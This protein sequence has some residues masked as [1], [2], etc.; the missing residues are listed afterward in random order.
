MYSQGSI[1]LHVKGQQGSPEPV[2]TELFRL[3][4]RQGAVASFWP[5]PASAESG[6]ERVCLSHPPL[7][8]GRVLEL[9]APPAPR[10]GALRV[11]GQPV[12][13]QPG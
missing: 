3:G 9:H 8:G 4:D 10:P 12:P 5:E 11:G 1:L 13:A 7:P 2:T 6:H